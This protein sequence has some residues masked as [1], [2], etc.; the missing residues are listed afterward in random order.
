M[1]GQISEEAML[2]LMSIYGGIVLII[3]YD[4]VRIFRRIFPAKLFR[5]IVEDAI[6]WTFASIFMFNIFLRYN[7]G[8]PRFF[9][10]IMALGT[11]AVFEWII[12]RKII[13]A[14]ALRIKKLGRILAKPLKKLCKVVKLIFYKVIK[15][16]RAKK[17]KKNAGRKRKKSHVKAKH[18]KAKKNKE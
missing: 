4:V 9:S 5:V 15:N 16:I 14:L 12:G 17:E 8:K 1:S 7:Y 2:I 10:V 18:H 13:D 3:C 6:Y 11:M